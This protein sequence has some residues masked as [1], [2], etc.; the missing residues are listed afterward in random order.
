M[1]FSQEALKNLADGYSALDTKLDKLIE[2][3]VG[4]QL[5][6]PRARE[7]ASQGFP[8]RL[9]TMARCIKNVFGLIPRTAK[10]FRQRTNSRTLRLIFRALCL[11]PMERLIILRGY[12]SLRR[13]KNGATRRIPDKHIGLGPDNTSVRQ[14][15]SP[16]FQAYLAGLDEWLRFL[17]EIS[18]TRS[19][20]GYRSTFRP[21]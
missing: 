14:T 17:A 19:R 18:G 12:W 21:T 7:F 4:L 16:E 8:R 10:S 20:I 6:Q 3:Y 15:L 13:E 1:Y 9:K 11:T 5:S 2:G